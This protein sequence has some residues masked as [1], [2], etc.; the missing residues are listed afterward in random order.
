MS[1][2]YLFV[3]HQFIEQQL[4]SAAAAHKTAE[5]G[6]FEKFFAEGRLNALQ[7]IQE[8]ISKN[9]DPKLPKRLYSRLKQ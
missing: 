1:H 5:D 7:E 9:V 4:A 8:Y 3:T 6:T 2:N